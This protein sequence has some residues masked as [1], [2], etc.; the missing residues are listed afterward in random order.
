MQSFP[1]VIT[2]SSEKGGVG[3]TTLATNLAIFIKALSEDLPVSIF[4]FDNHFTVDKMFEIKGQPLRGSVVD[5]LLETPGHE[6]LHTGQYGVNYIPS[7]GALNDLKHS[8][9][10]SMVLA[11]L[12]AASGI[13]GVVIIDTRPDLDVLTQNALYAADRVIIPVKDMASL[14]NCRNIFDLFDQKGL[15][16][17]SLS[18][19]PCL[20]D[21]RIK[22]EGI[23]RDQRTLLKSY[24][25]NRGY[26]CLDTY[27]SKSPKVES[28]STNPD[29]RVYPILTYARGTEVYGQFHQLATQLLREMKQV[30]EPRSLLFQQWYTAEDNRKKEEF[31][32]RLTGVRKDCPLC[33]TQL[34]RQDAG[35]AA[36]Y[37]ETS[38]GGSCGFIEERCFLDLL[39][40][41]VYQL[42]K[43]VTE[44]D[45][46]WHIFLES[47]RDST[48]L[49][50][51]LKGSD[52]HDVEFVQF[53]RQ[54]SPLLKKRHP[55]KEH[56]GSLLSRERSKLYGMM[57]ETL[58]G[59]GESFR[60]GFLLIHPTN[61]QEPEAILRE[62]K[63]REFVKLKR[64]AAR[65]LEAEGE[66]P[67]IG[68][69]QPAKDPSYLARADA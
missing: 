49:L 26:R 57:R 59:Y 24:A 31:Y 7:S 4:S 60:D 50:R 1:Y 42:G 14:E 48:F 47:A 41:N 45:P 10:G 36:F 62:E 11:R 13:P 61:P 5:L 12:L 6:L 23:F 66:G 53:D 29:G 37:F 32:A 21:S 55:L 35:N 51:P 65:Y 9:K 40:S 63:Y 56:E 33:R 67:V 18:L 16:R 58:E 43:T 19:I 68:A 3:K 34:P 25:I 46:T 17:K 54:G 8:F 28:L 2:V 30:K 44:N 27:I 39:F 22:F 20:I 38:D 69:A 64:Q 52:G 15:D